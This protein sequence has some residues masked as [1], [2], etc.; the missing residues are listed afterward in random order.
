M[1]WIFMFGFQFAWGIVPWLFPSE[2]FKNNERDRALSLSTFSGFLFNLIVGQIAQTLFH[3]NEGGMFMIFGVLNAANVIFVVFCIKETK[4][5][6]LEDVPALFLSGNKYQQ[7]RKSIDVE[8][9]YVSDNIKVRD[10]QRLQ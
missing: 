5:V 7:P 8:M 10:S 6:A 3:W 4:G 1:V 2:I 9:P